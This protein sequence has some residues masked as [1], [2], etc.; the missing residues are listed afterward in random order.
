M[1]Y[2]SLCRLCHLP[3]CSVHR[4]AAPLWGLF[5]MRNYLLFRTYTTFANEI[6]NFVYT[7]DS[8]VYPL[9]FHLCLALSR[10][11]LGMKA[12][13]ISGCRARGGECQCEQCVQ[14]TVHTTHRTPPAG[15]LLVAHYTHYPDYRITVRP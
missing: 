4:S 11:L 10:A 15:A 1:H 14:T 8:C 12:S 7:Q 13:A 3:P 9:L 5:K 2:P 6:I